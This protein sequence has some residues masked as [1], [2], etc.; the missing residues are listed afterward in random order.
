MDTD[1]TWPH[2]S[3]VTISNN[4][5]EN[6]GIDGGSNGRGGG[7][8]VAGPRH[9]ILG[10]VIRNNKADRGAGIGRIATPDDLLIEG[11]EISGNE[12][13][14]DHGAG[15]Y[16]DGRVTLRNNLVQGNR[17]V[18]AYGWGGGILIYEA[19][20]MSGN[21]FR[22]N[23]APTYAG[24]VFVDEGGEAWLDHEL[25]YANSIDPGERGGAGIAVDD[26][27]PALPSRVHIT[28]CTIANNA[29]AGGNGNGLYLDNGAFAEVTNSVFW[30]NGDDVFVRPDSTSASAV[31]YT[32]LQEAVPGNGNI[33]TDPLFADAANGDFRLRS[34]AGRWDPTAGAWVADALHSP[35]I[36]AGDPAT[37]YSLEPAPNGNRVNLGCYGNTSQASKSDS[38]IRRLYLPLVIK[39]AVQ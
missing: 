5:I 15:I 12:G 10:N 26:G 4:L 29:A 6:N 22:Q 30:G 27:G 18:G 20:R 23:H 35:G 24:A 14:G 17:I 39:S 1:M 8:A 33:V 11:N 36:D 25:I 16:L 34:R 37:G 9:R 31:R 28:H 13:H 32:L 19:R 21:V 38:G 3:D 7:I 2:M